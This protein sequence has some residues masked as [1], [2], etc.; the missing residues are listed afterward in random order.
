MHEYKRLYKEYDPDNLVANELYYVIAKTWWSTWI[1]YINCNTGAEKVL[2]AKRPD[3]INNNKLME[4]DQLRLRSD[5]TEKKEYMIITEP[6]WVA[7]SNWYGGGPTISRRVIRASNKKLELELYPLLL[8]ICICTEEGIPSEPEEHLLSSKVQTVE[9]V[10]KRICQIFDYPVSKCRLWVIE[11]DRD[12]AVLLKDEKQTLEELELC[13]EPLIMLEQMSENGKWIYGEANNHK[14]QH[15]NGVPGLVGLENLGNTC[16][17][18]CALQCLC[19]TALF[20]DYFLSEAYIR[21]INTESLDGLNGEFAVSFGL[22]MQAIWNSSHRIIAPRRFKGSLV[23]LK[24]QFQGFIQHDAQE[25][26]SCI[27][28]VS[29]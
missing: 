22:L 29:I 6:L 21:H 8:H 9:R 16:Y 17:M 10:K 14:S 27:L 13:E 15:T 2:H 1:Q 20:K 23:E 7:L 11:N 25:L 4:D 26:L 5:L 24:P 12:D 19:H 18:N 3:R 28:D